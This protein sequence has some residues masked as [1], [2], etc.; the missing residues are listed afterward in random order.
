MLERVAHGRKRELVPGN[1]RLF[2]EGDLERLSACLNAVVNE[3]GPKQ[4]IDLADVRD[5]VDGVKRPDF[6]TGAGFFQRFARS[7][8]LERL[9]HLEIACRYCPKAAARLDSAPAEQ[10][11]VTRF[12]DAAYDHSRILIV[13]RLAGVADMT[14]QSVACGRAKRHRSAA[15]AAEFHGAGNR[16]EPLLYGN[17]G[18]RRTRL[19]GHSMERAAHSAGAFDRLRRTG[20]AFGEAS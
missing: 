10:D 13:D 5:V 4:K 19:Q 14:L 8:L 16:V 15:L 6:N 2:A 20:V 11:P 1:I 17:I 9:S 12:H 7:A 3:L 18:G